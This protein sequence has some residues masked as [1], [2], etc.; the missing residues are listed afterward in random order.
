[1]PRRNS[2]TFRMGF[3]SIKNKMLQPPTRNL[4]NS[5]RVARIVAIVTGIGPAKPNQRPQGIHTS[6][7][8]GIQFLLGLQIGWNHLPGL[9]PTNSRQRYR[10]I[11]KLSNII[12]CVNLL[13]DLTILGYLTFDIVSTVQVMPEETYSCMRNIANI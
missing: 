7:P 9:I 5:C 3:S 1:M 4:S 2:K 10:N 12:C 6:L 11:F 13:N 8:R